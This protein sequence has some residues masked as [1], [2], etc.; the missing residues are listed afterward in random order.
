MEYS[1][2]TYDKQPVLRMIT[3]GGFDSGRNI[4]CVSQDIQV[5]VTY[6]LFSFSTP[7]G[8]R[9]LTC[10]QALDVNFDIASAP[11]PE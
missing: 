7:Y 4:W 3:H 6:W 11:L 8:L 1:T 2:R 9:L 10:G 5:D